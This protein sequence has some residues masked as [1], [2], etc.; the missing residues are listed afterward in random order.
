M[1]KPDL[2]EVSWEHVINPDGPVK[3]ERIYD[4]FLESRIKALEE[5]IEKLEEKAK[6]EK[7]EKKIWWDTTLWNSTTKGG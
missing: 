7:T 2:P 4:G 1:T 6:H 5:R 3:V